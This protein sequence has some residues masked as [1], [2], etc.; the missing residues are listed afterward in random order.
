MTIGRLWAKSTHPAGFNRKIGFSIFTSL[1][2]VCVLSVPS[3]QLKQLN[4]LNYLQ[5]KPFFIFNFHFFSENLFKVN[6]FWFRVFEITSEINIEEISISIA[7]ILMYRL[8][9]NSMQVCRCRDLVRSSACMHCLMKAKEISFEIFV[10]IF[11]LVFHVLIQKERNVEI[12]FMI[13]KECRT[14]FS[15][16]FLLWKMCGKLSE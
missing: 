12:F 2:C 8:N 6:F 7:N 4:R 15:I 16:S 1:S 14:L 13:S 11:F 5:R 10:T 3:T 9:E